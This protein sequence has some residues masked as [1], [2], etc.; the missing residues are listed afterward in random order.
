MGRDKEDEERRWRIGKGCRNEKGTRRMGRGDGGGMGMGVGLGRARRMRRGAMR[1]GKKGRVQGGWASDSKGEGRKED[2]KEKDTEGVWGTCRRRRRI[3][4]GGGKSAKKGREICKR[5][6]K[7]GK[8]GGRSG[9][10][11]W[12]IKGV[13]GG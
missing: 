6:K 13:G 11:S 1:I 7:L 9:K 10:K 12:R 5:G 3:F 4:E 2:R 8:G